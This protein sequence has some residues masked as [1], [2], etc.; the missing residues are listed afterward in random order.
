MTSLLIVES[1]AKCSKIQGFLGPGWR[2]IATMGHIRAL[3]EDL[4]AVGIQRD[5][6]PRFAFLKEKSKAINQIKECARFATTI[7]L[8][9]DDDREGEAISYSVALLLKLDPATTPRAVFR[10]ITASAV[11]AAVAA[12][13]RINMDRVWAQQAR[14]VLDMMVG[15]TISPLLWKYVGQG[16]SAG[17]CQT[18]ALRLLVDREKE[19]AGFRAET[20]WRVSGTWST[21]ASSPTPF[22]ATM[23]EELE[24][25][26][27]AMNYLENLHDDAG[28][29]VTAAATKP[30]TEQPPKPL[31]T[32]TLQQEVSATMGIQPKNTMRI[33]QR[34]YEAGHIT[35]MRTDSAVLSEEARLAAETWVRETFGAEYVAAAAPTA[36]AP[37]PSSAEKGKGKKVA[38]GKGADAAASP[39]AAQEAH[40]AI[41]PTH[42]ELTA[43]PADEDWN[44]SDRKVY[45]LIWNRA[46]Q[47]TMAACR[48]ESRT[49]DFTAAGD[50]NE[51]IWRTQWRRTTFP[52]WRRIGAAATDL[53]K[54]DGSDGEATGVTPTAGAPTPAAAQWTAAQALVPGTALQWRTLAAAPFESRPPARYTE[55]TLVREL[56]KKGIGRPSTFA[57][58]IGSIMDKAYAE[59]RDT[60]AR[61]VAVPRF[62]LQRPGQWP[63]TATEEKKKVGAERQKLAPTPLGLSVIEFLEREF[64]AL[65]AYSFTAQMEGRLDGIATGREPWKALCRDTWASYSAKVETMKAGASPAGVGGA[66]ARE[67]MFA[68]GIKAVQSKKGP[69]LLKEEPVAPG[70]KST[71]AVFYGWPEGVAFGEITEEQVAAFVGA[72]AAGKVGEEL[73]QHKGK[74][75]VKKSGPYGTYAE[76]DG[77]KVPWAEGDTGV[78]LAAKFEA[79]SVAVLHTLGPFEFRTGPYGVYFFKTDAT[80]AQRKFVSLPAAVDPKALTQE[81]AVKLYQTG[82]QQKARATAFGASGSATGASGTSGAS[83]RGGARG[84]RGGFRGGR[85][86]RGGYV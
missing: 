45:K 51:F 42:F 17:R 33:A 31:I 41:R 7:Y 36:D 70:K 72:K 6:E 60:A 25:S 43:L 67:R 48:G 19:I 61:E 9:S 69:L 56:E 47:S 14:A 78:T 71:Q 57:Q 64:A 75:I 39:P 50:P 68:G 58:L 2:V 49:V 26:E 62:T 83:G 85:G 44:A 21:K 3:E 38:K 22:E 79:K 54:E 73:G 32:S 34:L 12:P 53:D 16:L 8:A 37:P 63:A 76:C 82:L 5:F 35:Y 66:A 86:G 27:S 65:F 52:G 13:R 74:A 77:V 80:G 10:E 55:A 29:T 11:K 20:A 81:A 15:F 46:V 28:G 84:G 18:P 24:D 40:E 59:K 4:D 23:I 30:T 1:P